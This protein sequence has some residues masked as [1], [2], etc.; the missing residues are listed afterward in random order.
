MNEGQCQRCGRVTNCLEKHHIAQ[1]SHGGGDDSANIQLLCPTCHRE[2]HIPRYR[3]NMYGETPE[4]WHEAREADCTNLRLDIMPLLSP[5]AF[6]VYCYAKRWAENVQGEVSFATTEVAQTL[7]C[8]TSTVR[9]A[10]RELEGKGA[11]THWREGED[12]DQH[13]QRA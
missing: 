5:T 13:F 9:K 12:Y 11:I 2:A 4:A 3:V 7:R 6:R 1:R 10:L 8:S